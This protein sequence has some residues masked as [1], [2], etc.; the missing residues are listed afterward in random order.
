MKKLGIFLLT[1]GMVFSAAGSAPAA[2]FKVSGEY[3]VHL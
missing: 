2:D 1:A 3:N